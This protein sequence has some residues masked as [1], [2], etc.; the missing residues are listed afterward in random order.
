MTR[1]DDHNLPAGTTGLVLHRAALY[2][3]A[4][5][6]MTLGREQAFREQILQLIHLKAGESVLDVGCGTGGLAIAAKR[7]V[8][9]AGTVHG[10]DASA[11]MLARAEKK[12]RK[13][14][15][16][17]IFKQ[18]AAQAL[19]FPDGQFDA[20]LST[21][22]F[23]HLP[24]TARQQCAREMGRVLKPGGRVLVVDFA[25]PKQKESGI[26]RRFHRHSHVEHGEIISV[27]EAAALDIVESGAMQ[28]R[29][30]KYALA[31]MPGQGRLHHGAM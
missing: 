28:F 9:P 12:A 27:L 29:N 24:R 17:I 26:V 6:L 23:H 15:S 2:D 8:G 21:A 4:V 18:A 7:H 13:A 20:V 25:A 31:T 5:W 19:P 11:E 16:E 1:A 3:L 30:L 14:G 22:M 10:I